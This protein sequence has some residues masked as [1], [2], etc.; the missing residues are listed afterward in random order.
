MPTPKKPGRTRFEI[1]AE[2]EWIDLVARAA[3][4]ADRTMSSYARVAITAQMERDGFTSIPEPAKPKGRPPTDHTEHDQEP[5]APR[6]RALK[7]K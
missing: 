7:G 1:V 6:N 2:P 3:Q 4:A 5:K